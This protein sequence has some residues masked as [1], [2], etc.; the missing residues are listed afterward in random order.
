MKRPA[1]WSIAGI[2]VLIAGCFAV[3]VMT[4]QSK[5]ASV[6]NE[7]QANASQQAEAPGEIKSRVVLPPAKFEAAGLHS[8]AVDLRSL[9]K[10]RTVPGK[11]DY[12]AINRVDLKAPVESIVQEV[13]VKPGDA[14]HAGARLAVLESPEIGM[15]RADVEKNNAELTIATKAYNWAE[16][17]AQNLGDLLKVLEDGPKPQD[18]ER[19][20]E[21]KLLG[22][23]RQK[24]LGAYSRY[25]LADQL[26]KDI[27]EL[28]EKGSISML[29]VK[30]RETNREVAKAEFRAV[31][32]QSPVEAIQQRDKALANMDYARRLLD[33][34]RQKLKTLLGAFTEL[35]DIPKAGTSDGSELTRYYVVAPFAGTVE[36]RSVANSQRVAASAPLFVVAN[37]D[38]LDVYAEIRERDAQA[39]TLQPGDSVNVTIPFLEGHKF[40]ATVDYVGR[41]VS[42]ETHAVP[43]VAILSNAQHLLKPGMFAWISLPMGAT[44][45]T[46]VIPPSALLTH[47]GKTFV[48]VEDGQHAFRRV[49]VTTGTETQNGVAITAGLR[50]HERVVDRG[51]F[52]LKSELLKP[53][54]E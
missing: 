36:Q 6:L 11:I 14:V 51:A 35:P 15:V 52:V 13:R 30:T 33:V 16:Q 31:C 20:F 53:E 26:N 32:E 43:L 34:S 3:Y 8:T 12:R 44:D 22:D 50:A 29:T 18:V 28:A 2:S 24:V 46:L 19:Q 37:T 27:Q 1:A 23:H 17:V 21:N 40:V 25:V 4:L 49:D 41:A 47:D 48:F 38:T 9:Q 5:R 10:T 39:L 7:P 54:E 42:P 45:E